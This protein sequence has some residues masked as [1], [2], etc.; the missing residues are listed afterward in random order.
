MSHAGKNFAALEVKRFLQEHGYFIYVI[1][2][3]HRIKCS[4]YDQASASPLPAC[5]KCFG[6]GYGVAIVK[7]RTYSRSQVPPA[8]GQFGAYHVE[9]LG[10][11]EVGGRYYY[12]DKHSVVGRIV[13]VGDL[14]LEPSY[15][16]PGRMVGISRAYRVS[17]VDPYRI[18]GDVTYRRAAG[19]LLSS[20][21]DTLWEALVYN[22][23]TATD[24]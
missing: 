20:G 12:F 11:I 5:H 17:T 9:P 21:I 13:G 18:Y 1:S 19:S 10:A 6:T 3:D 23:Q 14:I 24:V 7:G 22:L 8:W 16:E 2:M 15:D 4:C